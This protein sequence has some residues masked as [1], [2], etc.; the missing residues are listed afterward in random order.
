MT[1]DSRQWDIVKLLES[2]GVE[3]VPSRLHWAAVRCPFHLDREASASVNVTKGVFN[4]H[5]CQ[6][7]G[8]VVQILMGREGLTYSDAFE[9]AE[10]EFRGSDSGVRKTSTG[11]P[12]VSG[13][14]RVH[15]RGAKWIAPWRR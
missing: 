5:A 1:H 12:S 8:N 4:C 15:R 9:R 14:P 11:R 3:R 6:V 13:K 10:E 7:S 2:Y